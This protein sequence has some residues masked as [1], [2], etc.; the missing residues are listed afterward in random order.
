[1]SDLKECSFVALDWLFDSLYRRSLSLCMV[2]TLS[3]EWRREH[4]SSVRKR[5]S[6]HRNREN[7]AEDTPTTGV[8]KPARSVR[9]GVIVQRTIRQKLHQILF[10]DRPGLLFGCLVAFR[11]VNVF[12]IRSAFDPDEYWQTLEPA[13]C[14]VFADNFVNCST[15]ESC[16][17]LTWE[18]TRR[19]KLDEYWW[20]QLL[21]G[22]VRS[23]VSVLPTDLFYRLLR[24]L[25]SATHSW[26]ARGPMIVQAITVAAPIDWMVWFIARQV[27]H[28]TPG[29]AEWTLFSSLTSW[30]GAFCWVRTYANCQEAL[31]LLVAI[32]LALQNE[33]RWEP[34]MFFLGGISIAIRFT[35]VAAFVPLG[36]VLALQRRKLWSSRV[37]FLIRICAG[38]GILGMVVPLLVDRVFFGFWAL[39]FL[40]NFHFN[41]LLG[42]ARIYGEHSW[43]WYWIAGI[44]AVA[45]LLTPTLPHSFFWTAKSRDQSNM[46]T[47]MRVVA[48]CYI[49][50]LSMS[51]HKEFRFLL[52]VLPILVILSAPLL[53]HILRKHAVLQCAWVLTN[54]VAVLYLGIFHQSG[55][56][57]VN[58]EIVR[59][60]ETSNH[61]VLSVHYLLPCHSTPSRSHLHSLRVQFD[62]FH[63][64]CSPNCR[65]D[66]SCANDLFAR[67][68]ESFLRERYHGGEQGDFP[69]FVVT[70]S[71]TEAAVS[72][73]IPSLRRVASFPYTLTGVHITP[74][75]QV[76]SRDVILL[77]RA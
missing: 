17:H 26:V 35:A 49:M 10:Q 48:L 40:G 16:C 46:L 22:P 39:P 72:A 5:F 53:K 44:P 2:G 74:S 28:S 52:P 24:R 61:E 55:A 68:P 59:L 63:L 42:M 12:F 11:L 7:N 45:G 19:A 27:Y 4:S 32:T 54:L 15:H 14:T 51:P 18:W 34:L 47:L 38:C 62:V 29:L 56:I 60:A 36:I 13:Y 30:F 76:S 9:A 23:Y 1:M 58:N 3:N 25:G 20:E 57:S 65:K 75:V 33:K 70:M 50:V 8:S 66:N 31:L 6:Q 67:D 69:D 64:D 77:Q 41:A 73:A 21:H 37:I 43:P 71:E